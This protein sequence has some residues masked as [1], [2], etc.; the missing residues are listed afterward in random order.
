MARALAASAR[1]SH[2]QHRTVSM[3]ND[4][5][6]GAAQQKMCDPGKPM[7]ANHD[8]LGPNGAARVCNLRMSSPDPDQKLDRLSGLA[9]RV[10]QRGQA[11]PSGL[12]QSLIGL[13][14][15]RRNPKVIFLVDSRLNNVK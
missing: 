6:S 13:S 15:G 9:S 5:F 1:E 12:H 10:R 4:S 11:L 2:G 3:P 14:H 7:S 8:E